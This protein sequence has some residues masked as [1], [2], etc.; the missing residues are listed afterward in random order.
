M[1]DTTGNHGRRRS[2]PVLT[3]SEIVE[4]VLE[5]GDRQ[6]VRL[7]EI[8]AHVGQRSYGPLLLV[9]SLLVV[10]PLSAIPGFSSLVAAYVILVAG[11]MLIGR[12][13]PWLP[14]FVVDLSVDRDRLRTAGR[15]LGK[16]AERVDLIVGVRLEFLTV[17]LSARLVAAMCMLLAAVV[18]FLELVPTASSIIGAVIALYGL[19]L[20]AHDGLLLIVALAMTIGAGVFVGSLIL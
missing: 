18:P 14:G 8:L 1:D 16:V 15:W 20:A 2:P 9:P 17:G 11:Q 19:A 3:L 7:G 6:E 4:R 10:S 5:A 13:S 12:R